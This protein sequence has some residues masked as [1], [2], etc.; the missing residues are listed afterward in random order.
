[1]KF[2]YL[3]K[4]DG[5]YYPAGT[6][7]PIET[8]SGEGVKVPAVDVSGRVDEVKDGEEENREVEEVKEEKPKPKYTETDLDVPYFSLLSMAKKEGLNVPDK[9]KTSDLKKMLRAL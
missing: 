1:M 6:D 4:H 7:V 9:A 5:V 8:T 3:V 2:D